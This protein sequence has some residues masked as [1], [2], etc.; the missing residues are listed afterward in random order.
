MA[1]KKWFD[2]T[3]ANEFGFE[4]AQVRELVVTFEQSL[5]EE[6]AI[7]QAAVAAGDGLK[8]AN[9]LHALKGFMPLFTEAGLA[10]T[11]TDLYQTSREQPLTVTGPLFTALV[12]NLTS[13]LL[14]VRAWLA[15]STA[16][17][18]GCV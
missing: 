3:R 2:L 5:Q 12:P 7:I 1:S 14:E 13:L 10:Q 18:S 11:I 15:T 9:A 17:D 16:Y 6:I 8:T 4:E